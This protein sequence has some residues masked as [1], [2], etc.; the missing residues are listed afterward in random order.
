[1]VADVETHF[2]QPVTQPNQLPG[3]AMPEVLASGQ[4]V[5]LTAVMV[6]VAAAVVQVVQGYLA[7]H[8]IL[9]HV[10]TG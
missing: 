2:T 4:V 5:D 7:L 3:L 9:D 10:V 1:V 8:E 6:T